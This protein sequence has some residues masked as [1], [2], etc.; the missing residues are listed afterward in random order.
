M[1][2]KNPWKLEKDNEDN[3]LWELEDSIDASNFKTITLHCDSIEWIEKYIYENEEI[4]K[5][6]SF[7][8]GSITIPVNE[9]FDVS[10]FNSGLH[11]FSIYDLGGKYSFL[12]GYKE[13]D[14]EE[15]ELI[16]SYGDDVFDLLDDEG[17][18]SSTIILAGITVKNNY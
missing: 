15:D 18:D 7:D 14:P 12:G 10:I 6:H 8:S 11:N 9:E 5:I 1:E 13:F 2:N 3:F 4:K 17:T 16:D